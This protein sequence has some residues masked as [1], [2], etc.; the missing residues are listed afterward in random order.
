MGERGPRGEGWHVSFSLTHEQRFLIFRGAAPSI[1]FPAAKPCPAKKGDV[2]PL[3]GTVSIEVLDVRRSPDAKVWVLD[4]LVND[5]RPNLL[6]RVPQ[7]HLPE[8]DETGA[9]KPPTK[10]DI[11]AARIESSYTHSPRDAVPSAGEGL[12]EADTN[13]LTMRART[14]MAE[15]RRAED[16][17]AEA[18]ADVQRINSELRELG[19]RAAKMGLDVTAIMAPIAKQIEDAH[20]ELQNM[21]DAA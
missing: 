9:I 15:R 14:K 12:P 17:A 16:P 21:R 19:Q 1:T 7:V 11:E 8:K 3:S 13:L 20:A 2:K 6:R 4:Y 18:K 10:G 5:Q